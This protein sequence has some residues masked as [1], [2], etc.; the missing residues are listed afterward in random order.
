MGNSSAA[1]T[2]QEHSATTGWSEA[3]SLSELRGLLLGPEQE[4]LNALEEQLEHARPSAQRIAGVLPQAIRQS[5]SEDKA[6]STALMPTVEEIVGL[7]VKKNPKVFTDALFPVMGPAI[8][9]A[10]GETFRRMLQTLNQALESS[11][12]WQGLKWRLEAVRSGRPFAEVV[13]LHSLIFRVE[14]IFLIHSKSGLL[15]EH[16]AAEDAVPS[17]SDMVSGMLTAI[18]DFV[19]D[20]FQTD[21]GEGL[22]TIQVGELTV[23]IEQGPLAILAAVIHGSAP[24]ELRILFQDVLARIHLEHGTILESFDGDASPFASVR[25]VLEDCLLARYRSAKRSMSPRLWILVGILIFAAAAWVAFAV[26]GHLR[27]MGVLQMLRNQPGIVVTSAEKHG[28]KYVLTGLRDPLATDPNALLKKAGINPEDVQGVWR[29]YQAL[30]PE[31]I[32]A[33]AKRILTPPE[34][35]SLCLKNQD[36]IATGYAPEAWLL[37]ARVLA[38]G[39][40][41]VQRFV[42]ND[43]Q[44][45]VDEIE[46]LARRIDSRTLHFRLESDEL[47]PGQEELV[48]GV[49]NDLQSLSELAQKTHTGVSVEVVGHTDASGPEALNQTLRHKRAETVRS[50]LVAKGVEPGLLV[51]GSAPVRGVSPDAQAT[52]ATGDLGRKV[53]FRVH[54]SKSGDRKAGVP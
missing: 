19:R 52:V 18:Q 21:K 8:R 24:E 30:D 37:E 31:F 46:E 26:K 22:E 4:R 54:L 32:L 9:K 45:T 3:D 17:G 7:S 16:V 12:S 39:I 14:Q 47:D 36:L 2:D 41:G 50:M 38:R 20:S 1:D 10:I 5:A 15:L 49:A 13:L 48:L 43:L 44:V 34:G 42:D 27:W 33:R 28:G 51:A 35:V 11:L 6:L 40:A 53:M 25:S 29:S 23:W